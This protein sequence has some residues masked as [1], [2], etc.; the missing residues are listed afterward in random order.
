VVVGVL[1]IV[2]LLA[3]LIGALHLVPDSA[4]RTPHG[5]T[6]SVPACPSPPSAPSCTPSFRPRAAASTASIVNFAIGAVLT[7][8]FVAWE[9]R[10]D[11]PMLDIALFRNAASPPAARPLPSVLRHGRHRVPA[12]PV[13]AVRARVHPACRRLALVPAAIGMLSAP[14]PVPTS[15]EMHGGRIA[16]TA[17]TL[18]AAA[19]VA[20]QAVPSTVA[21]RAHR[22]RPACSASVPACD[23]AA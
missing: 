23:A 4:T 10:R 15:A 3:V 9:M 17:G 7:V 8:V 20:V 5:S 11:D 22:C 14:A 19:G 21:K 16:V 18:I 2:P 13:P 6:R 12:G 1:I